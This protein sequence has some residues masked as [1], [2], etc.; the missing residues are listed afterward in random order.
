VSARNLPAAKEEKKKTELQLVQEALELEKSQHAQ[1][2]REAAARLASLQKRF[3]SVESELKLAVQHLRRSEEE[4]HTE[5]MRLESE[6]TRG[7]QERHKLME[8]LEQNSV[9]DDAVRDLYLHMKDRTSEGELTQEQLENERDLLKGQ[10]VLTVLGALHANLKML[11]AFKVDAEAELRG[12]AA[13]RAQAAADR[14][15]SLEE[16][17]RLQLTEVEL[18]KSALETAKHELAEER[19]LRGRVLGDCQEEQEQMLELQATL[20]QEVRDLMAEN[21]RLRGAVRTAN[22]E[23][24]RRDDLVLKNKELESAA[25]FDKI[26]STNKLRQQWH[27]HLLIMQE[28]EDE[29][30]KRELKLSE[31]CDLEAKLEKA[32]IVIESQKRS[33]DMQNVKRLEEK[34]QRLSRV[35]DDR[36]AQIKRLS[37][38]LAHFRGAEALE[39][40]KVDRTYNWGTGPAEVEE[41]EDPGQPDHP[42]QKEIVDVKPLHGKAVS[43]IDDLKG[44]LDKEPF[45]DKYMAKTLATMSGRSKSRK[46][47]LKVSSSSR[48]ATS[49]KPPSSPAAPRTPSGGINTKRLQGVATKGSMRDNG[50]HSALLAEKPKVAV[51]SPTAKRAASARPKR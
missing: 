34:N 50:L 26:N 8:K 3:A 18:A 49:Q 13:N 15:N 45:V 24:R 17:I 33:L 42:M 2:K 20:T 40:T 47:L 4:H 1:S 44:E 16:Q 5:I 30:K 27:E 37:K 10:N 35:L 51:P 36:D 23:G 6:V 41:A 32:T 22:E 7:V 46:G 9:V 12:R 25:H 28:M 31:K 29:V 38:K 48:Q 19:R 39:M 14:G 21:E 11:W 43:Q